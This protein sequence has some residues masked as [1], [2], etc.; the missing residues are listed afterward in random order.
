MY[1]YRKAFETKGNFCKGLLRME[2]W[3][4]GRIEGWKDGKMEGWK[5]G[6]MEGWKDGKMERW[7]DGEMGR[8]NYRNQLNFSFLHIY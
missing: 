5:D 4:D 3:K 8:R 1:L 2:G 7:K 6:R